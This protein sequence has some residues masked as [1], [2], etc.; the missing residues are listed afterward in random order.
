M[1]EATEK[2]VRKIA[3]YYHQ[4]TV[5]VDGMDDDT[6]GNVRRGVDESTRSE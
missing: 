3:R 2:E 6:P 5:L 4:E 1:R